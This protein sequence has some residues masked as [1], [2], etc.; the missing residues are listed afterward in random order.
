LEQSIAA[1]AAEAY[2]AGHAAGVAEERAKVMD[3]IDWW[4]KATPKPPDWTPSGKAFDDQTRCLDQLAFYLSDGQNDTRDYIQASIDVRKA[5][6][7]R[8]RGE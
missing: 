8:A 5:A 6:A 4:H 7:L 3:F 2:Q 1:L